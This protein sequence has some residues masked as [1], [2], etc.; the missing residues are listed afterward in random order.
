MRHARSYI[1]VVA[2]LAVACAAWPAYADQPR[3]GRSQGQGSPS[4]RL[5]QPYY[6]FR[7]RLSIG[8]GVWLGFPVPYPTFDFAVPYPWLPDQDVTAPAPVSPQDSQRIGGPTG[9]IYSHAYPFPNAYPSPYPYLTRPRREAHGG[10]SLEFEP[11]DASVTVD[12]VF[13]GQAGAFGP[14]GPPLTLAPGRYR[15]EVSAPG[16]D[17]SAFDVTIAPGEVIPY[18]GRLHPVQ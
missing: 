12:G 9:P 5:R 16:F 18:R 17:P 2:L 13:L 6:R 3:G 8:L 7:P 11:A 1:T 14:L 4:A 10:V 15:I